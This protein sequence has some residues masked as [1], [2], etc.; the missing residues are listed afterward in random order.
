MWILLADS[1][2][3]DRAEAGIGAGGPQLVLA[4]ALVLMLFSGPACVC[5]FAST[6][7]HQYTANSY[8]SRTTC[9][10]SLSFS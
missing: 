6:T 4:V 7:A 9:C 3:C 8:G 2:V 10:I 5:V 1:L